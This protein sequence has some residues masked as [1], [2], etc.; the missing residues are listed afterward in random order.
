MK[1]LKSPGIG[2]KRIINEISIVLLSGTR[3][4]SVII[5]RKTAIQAGCSRKQLWFSK[6]ASVIC[7]LLKVCPSTQNSK[8][9]ERFQRSLTHYWPDMAHEETFLEIRDIT[10]GAPQPYD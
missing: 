4:S 8:P 5:D 9:V 3:G 2:I 10:A 1:S 7:Y 6:I